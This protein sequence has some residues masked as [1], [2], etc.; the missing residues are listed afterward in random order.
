M[1]RK[2]NIRLML[3]DEQ[4]LVREGLRCLVETQPDLTVVGATADRAEAIHLARTHQAKVALVHAHE[5]VDK[6]DLL[7]DLSNVPLAV[8]VLASAIDKAEAAAALQVGTRGIVVNSSTPDLLFK[9]IRSVAAGQYWIGR[10]AVGDLI[11][12]IRQL[13]TAGEPGGTPRRYGLTRR[14]LDIIAAV[15]A[16]DTNRVIAE[17]FSLSEDTVKHHLTHIFDKLGVFTR[18]E[19]ALFAIHHHLVPPGTAT[20]AVPAP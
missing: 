11:E 14:E 15:V 13:R 8:L 17:R 12:M 16:G 2:R 18:L 1:E 3:Y 5:H 19:L 7:R 9:S 10:Q 4:L 20:T 6:L